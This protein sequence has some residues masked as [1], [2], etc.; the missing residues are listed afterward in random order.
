M[1]TIQFPDTYTISP[2]KGFFDAFPNLK[3]IYWGKNMPDIEEDVIPNKEIVLFLPSN[4]PLTRI[5][6]HIPEKVIIV[7]PSS[8]IYFPFDDMFEDRKPNRSMYFTWDKHESNSSG[9]FKWRKE[10]P[11]CKDEVYQIQAF[12]DPEYDSKNYSITAIFRTGNGET[13]GKEI[14][15][16]ADYWKE[17]PVT[18]STDVV[19]SS[20]YV[21]QGLKE[22]QGNR[23]GK[24]A[25]QTR[26]LVIEIKN[27]IDQAIANGGFDRSYRMSHYFGGLSINHESLKNQL[28]GLSLDLA[29]GLTVITVSIPE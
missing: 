25:E 11:N 4:H 19:I 22:A 3:T 16:F 6:K 21:D 9:Y 13:I 7:I 12:K 8:N 26:E 27:A 15:C 17:E 14:N 10:V 23:D 20:A 2:P 29:Q 18:K 28:P 1:N 24:M 5:S